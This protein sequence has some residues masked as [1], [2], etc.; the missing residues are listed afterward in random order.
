MLTQSIST[1]PTTGR[2]VAPA[3]H[4]VP[5]HFGVL[6]GHAGVIATEFTY[7]KE[8]EIYGEDESS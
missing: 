1:S 5:D 3:P 8:E 7:R 6:T 2:K 4:V